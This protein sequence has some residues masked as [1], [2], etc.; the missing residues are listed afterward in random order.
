MRGLPAA[1]CLALIFC[2]CDWGFISTRSLFLVDVLLLRSWD[3]QIPC[4]LDHLWLIACSAHTQHIL[5]YIY[6]VPIAAARLP[7]LAMNTRQS[8]H[9]SLYY[10]P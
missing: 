10:I 4:C 1:V 7:Y 3:R 9:S 2:C 6:S 8:C 5:R